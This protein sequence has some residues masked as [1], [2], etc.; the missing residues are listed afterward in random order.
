[1][2]LTDNVMLH[3]ILNIYIILHEFLQFIDV[4]ASFNKGLFRNK[5][6]GNSTMEIVQ[7]IDSCTKVLLFLAE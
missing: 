7:K 1:M 3:F 5:E 6:Q 4:V 2:F